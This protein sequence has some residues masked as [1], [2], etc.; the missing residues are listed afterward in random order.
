MDL[1]SK[2]IAQKQVQ[3]G[4]CPFPF[5]TVGDK[6]LPVLFLAQPSIL[7]AD[8]SSKELRPYA[9]RM[10]TIAQH[11]RINSQDSNQSVI[12]ANLS[13]M[14][15]SDAL[16]L[17]LKKITESFKQSILEESE[18]F[19]GAFM[20]SILLSQ[21]DTG[22]LLE[23]GDMLRSV[24]ALADSSGT[25]LPERWNEDLRRRVDE[26]TKDKEKSIADRM[27]YFREK[28]DKISK[29]RST[30]FQKITSA[31]STL[32]NEL[33][34]IRRDEIQVVI[35]LLSD[36]LSYRDKVED[37][38]K[39]ADL[40]SH[41]LPNSVWLKS[42]SVVD[43]TCYLTGL[44]LGDDLPR[45]SLFVS[46]EPLD[47]SHRVCLY[48]ELVREILFR[49]MYGKPLNG[50]VPPDLDLSEYSGGVVM[51]YSGIRVWRRRDKPHPIS[52]R[53]ADQ[54]VVRTVISQMDVLKI[55]SDPRVVPW[56]KFVQT[57]CV[58]RCDVT[59]P[60]SEREFEKI[61]AAF[62]R[63]IPDDVLAIIMSKYHSLCQ[64]YERVT[65]KPPHFREAYREYLLSSQ[66]S[67]KRVFNNFQYTHPAFHEYLQALLSTEGLL[68]VFLKQ[69][70]KRD[71]FVMI[72]PNVV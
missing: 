62:E 19:V 71:E 6:P 70:D 63:Q 69:L 37:L 54:Y 11:V 48:R 72:N 26:L 55:L 56:W 67:Q 59:A 25:V 52:R 13:Q 7:G 47:G 49:E 39:Y 65:S 58:Y 60:P 68:P 30:A 4:G 17:G 43:L 8:D 18:R 21:R 40:P 42:R 2:V 22:L 1:Y 45:T 35:G 57:F 15:P 14:V 51:S 29:A 33:D 5:P 20:D 3:K 38:S 44:P 34:D 10:K 24:A 36:E 28:E 32:M 23:Q 12:L 41:R 50:D 27:G 64:K 16:P 46:S 9:K 31:V 53:P 61:M 66:D